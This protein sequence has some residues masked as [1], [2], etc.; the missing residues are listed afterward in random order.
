M[1]LNYDSDNSVKDPLWA[2]QKKR[3]RPLICILSDSEDEEQ[4]TRFNPRSIENIDLPTNIQIEQHTTPIHPKKK[5]T[6]NHRNE[7]KK[8]RVLGEAYL[9]LKKTNNKKLTPCVEK[10]K[11]IIKPRCSHT[12]L[13][14]NS[15]AKNSFLCALITDQEREKIHSYFW[16][17][18][19]WAEKKAFVRA[20]AVR[21]K[22]RR[23]R[24]GSN[25]GRQ[26]VV[27]IFS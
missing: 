17:L 22:I 20:A 5:K 25:S 14:T 13:N 1:I 15:K 8:A 26:E 3:R 11:R 23:R 4:P 7:N 24:K 21:R 12:N 27:M 6:V 10:P 18:E 2:P 16:T 19:S 9:G